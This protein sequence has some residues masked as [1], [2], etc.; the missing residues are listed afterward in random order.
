[1]SLD[2]PW[3]LREKEE[4]R[5]AEQRR[6]RKIE[7]DRK[8]REINKA[9]KAIVEANRANRADA[10][11][12]HPPQGL[13]VLL[14]VA[15]GRIDDDR[16]TVDDVIARKQ[17]VAMRMQVTDVVGS[18]PGRVHALDDELARFQPFGVAALGLQGTRLDFGNLQDPFLDFVPVE[19]TQPDG[20][21]PA[22]LIAITGSNPP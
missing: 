1:M 2:N 10:E 17:P 7:E 4:K 22:D 12:A 3:A 15:V 21:G 18:V 11:V 9:I 16:R 20:E 8:R 14:H 6:A 19:V 5:C 13:D